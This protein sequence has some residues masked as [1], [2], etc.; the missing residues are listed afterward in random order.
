MYLCDTNV[1]SEL[2]KSRPN[3]GVVSWLDSVGK[4]NL[5]VITVEEL[6]FG[7]SWR[8]NPRIAAWLDTLL[9]DCNILPVTTQIARE[10]GELRGSLQALG[11]PRTQSDLLIAA[12]ARH[13][14][15]VLAT[16]NVRDF[17]DCGVSV[18]DPFA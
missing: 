9:A 17:T 12:T 2:A 8:P 4:L 18:L 1:L 15:Y 7:L 5:S 6:Y 13:H 14:A 3:P 10:A 11:K 16:R